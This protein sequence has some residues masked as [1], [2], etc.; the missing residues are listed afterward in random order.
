MTRVAMVTW[1]DRYISWVRV[2]K[3]FCRALKE[4]GIGCRLVDTECETG[5][6]SD[7]VAVLVP[8]D[9][10]LWN[11]PYS[12]ARIVGRARRSVGF[13][14]MDATDLGPVAVAAIKSVHRVMVTFSSAV[15]T[16]AQYIPPTRI[17]VVHL[18]IDDELIESVDDPSKYADRPWMRSV[19]N[20]PRPRIMIVAHH[21]VKRKNIDVALKALEKVVKEVPSASV[22]IKKWSVG[23]LPSDL[24]L[25]RNTVVVNEF[26]TDD[27]MVALYRAVDIVVV[28][29]GAGSAELPA[30]EAAACGTIVVTSTWP[31]FVEYL[32]EA[33]KVPISRWEKLDDDPTGNAVNRG[34]VGRVDPDILAGMIINIV[35]DL[36]SV[37][38]YY[39]KHAEEVRRRWGFRRV[40]RYELLEV[41]ERHV[42]PY[43]G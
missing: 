42:F 38:E 43:M 33:L 3:L 22:V 7:E 2:S 23:F 41:L 39:Q 9:W 34:K 15:E 17:D 27:E 19:L 12:F 20:L 26:V 35:R 11:W 31:A 25:G 36:E 29:S 4:L 14:S 13:V 37:R 28:P 32:P 30:V 18:P 1:G 40:T 5:I 10:C 24:D 16:V 6:D 21:D 8:V